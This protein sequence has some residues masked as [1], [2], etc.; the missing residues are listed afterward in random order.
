ML[1]RSPVGATSGVWSVTNSVGTGYALTVF[2]VDVP[3]PTLIAGDYGPV[4]PGAPFS[5]SGQFLSTA[6]SVVWNGRSLAFTAT[7]DTYIG[8]LLPTDA[9]GSGQLTVTTRGGSVLSEGVL[10]AI[11]HQPTVAGQTGTAS[12]GVWPVTGD[13]G[14]QVTLTGA[15]LASVT[16]VVWNGMALTWIVNGDGTLSVDIPDYAT[17]TGAF[18]VTN[19]WGSTTSVGEFTVNGPL[20]TI[21]ELLSKGTSLVITAHLGRPKGER[22]PELSLAPIAKRLSEL[23]GKEVKFISSAVGVKAEIDSL[24]PGQ[25]ALLE[26]IRYEAAETSKEIGRAHV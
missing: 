3:A 14:S 2:T 20:P 21:N 13:A 18:T 5:I 15:S 23:L 4:E 17:G 8:A 26:N 6:Q 12:S 9:V 11:A 16:S 1:F 7:S 10:T 24:T 25:I 22:K 19:P